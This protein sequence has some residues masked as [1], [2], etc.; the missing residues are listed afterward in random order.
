MSGP[1]VLWGEPGSGSFTVEA[2]L[3]MAGA[4]V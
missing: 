3:A 1:F 4:E 2:V